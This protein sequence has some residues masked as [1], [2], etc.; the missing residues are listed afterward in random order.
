LQLEA[1]ERRDVG[2]H[3]NAPEHL[4]IFA[5]KDRRWRER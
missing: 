1:F 4:S 3:H 5:A 2:Q